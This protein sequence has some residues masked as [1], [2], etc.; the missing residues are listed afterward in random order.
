MIRLTLLF[1][2]LI[3]ALPSLSQEG[4][5]AFQTK[6]NK[7]L[8][9]SI[10]SSVADLDVFKFYISGLTFRDSN[11]SLF[12]PD[13]QFYLVDFESSESTAFPISFPA[14]F[15]PNRIEF[16]LGIDSLTNVSGVM[17]GDLDPMKGMY[18]TW[19]SGYINWKL[20]TSRFT[21]HI[22][23]YCSPFATAHLLSFPAFSID[24]N[25]VVDLDNIM[26]VLEGQ[27]KLNI[28]SPG[29]KAHDLSILFKN[30]ISIT[31]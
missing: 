4:S 6:V 26:A 12:Q 24:V 9:T 30:S 21:C 23:G 10:D 2:I 22:G 1:Q 18:W 31:E 20:E 8:Y 28:M 3:W 7:E 15:Q 19:Q 13:R 16:T 11:D 25:F 29:S 27:E 14:G 5:L 17:G